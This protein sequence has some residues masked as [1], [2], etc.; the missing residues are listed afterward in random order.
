MVRKFDQQ[1]LFDRKVPRKPRRCLARPN[2][3]GGELHSICDYFLHL[4][5][6]WCDLGTA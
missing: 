5:I 2:G 3:M 6:I 4:H 1:I